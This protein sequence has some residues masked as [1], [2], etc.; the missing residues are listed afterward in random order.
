MAWATHCSSPHS[1]SGPGWAA[2]KTVAIVLVSFFVSS[3][4]LS[5]L[6]TG[7]FEGGN[8]SVLWWMGHRIFEGAVDS[9][10]KVLVGALGLSVQ[11]RALR[12]RSQHT[13]KLK[14]LLHTGGMN[15]QRP[16]HSRF[17]SSRAT[18]VPKVSR[19]H[20]AGLRSSSPRFQGRTDFGLSL[21]KAP[22][23]WCLQLPLHALA[24]WQTFFPGE[25]DI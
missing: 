3:R 15:A 9:Q 6:D 4:A 22:T 24:V 14:Y 10:A 21:G 7:L 2:S 8:S 23:R 11:V 17:A 18:E 5:F 16:Q 20:L 1:S 19:Q 25:K 12:K 13:N